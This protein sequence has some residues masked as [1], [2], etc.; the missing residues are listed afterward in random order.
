MIEKAELHSGW[1]LSCNDT[2]HPGLPE[3]IPAAV[4][5]CVHLDLLANRLIPDP[6]LDVNE[7]SN[8]WIGR[9]EWTYRCSF[10][11]AP[12]ERKVHELVFDGLDTIATIRLNG[13]EVAR[14]FNQHRTYRF[15]VSA[16]LKAGVNELSVTFHSAYAHGAE[17][18]KRSATGPTIIPGPAT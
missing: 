14:S 2:E 15:D 8:D 18:E 16:L 17:M 10:E 3:F 6:Y 1:T 4:P 5:G 9:T 12:D 13:E 11:A 7:I